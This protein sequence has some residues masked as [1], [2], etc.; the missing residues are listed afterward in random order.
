MAILATIEAFLHFT[1]AHF[2]ANKIVG[3]VSEMSSLFFTL[4]S[5]ENFMSIN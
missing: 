1:C 4:C 5:T 3:F 2:C